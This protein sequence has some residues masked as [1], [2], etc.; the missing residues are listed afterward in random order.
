M[1]NV[2]LKLNRLYFSMVPKYIKLSIRQLEVYSKRRP[3]YVTVGAI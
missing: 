2:N 3:E 1:W